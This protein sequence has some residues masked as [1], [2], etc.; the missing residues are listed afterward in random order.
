M[1][2]G[3]HTA[4]VD[5]LWNARPQ[6]SRGP[7][8]ALSLE[9]I[10]AVAVEVADAEGLPAVS[11]E[12]VAGE[13]SFTKMSLYRYVP[14]K[15]ELVALMIDRAIGGV[16]AALSQ[17]D[18]WRAR[19]SGWS[20]E[21]FDRFVAHPWSL[22]STVGARPIGPNE[23]DWTEYAVAALDGLPLHPAEKLD[24]V[25]ILA[26]HVRSIAAQAAALGE[27]AESQIG[28][29][30]AGLALPRAERYPA[31]AAAMTELAAPSST[32]EQNDAL[33]FGL[34]RILDGI[35]AL[36]ATR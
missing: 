16:P 17:V 11:M 30:I 4:G 21:L 32:P 26:G 13:L 31:L 15:N 10:V 5:L 29:M 24:T 14:G 6:R 35:A 18:G 34:D 28:H 12:R 9:R 22:P 36:V 8:P 19:L 1:D 3:S 23:L 7:K 20:R 27:D 25:A 2:F 33:R